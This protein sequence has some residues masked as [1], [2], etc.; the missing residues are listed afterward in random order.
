MIKGER[1]R[2]PS[3]TMLRFVSLVLLA[4]ATTLQIF[5]HYAGVWPTRTAFDHARCQ[6]RSGLYLTST[7][8]VDPDESKWD[9]YRACLA[10]FLG[11]RALWLAGGLVLLAAVA[12]LIYL[13]RPSWRIR[14]RGLVPMPEELHEPLAALV[15]EAG[16]TK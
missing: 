3:G 2:V 6:V 11:A 15:A 9:G 10:T 5:G 4:V 7:H 13:A 12:L 14:R 1:P 8:Q 16:L